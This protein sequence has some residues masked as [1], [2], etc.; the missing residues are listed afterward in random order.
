[1]IPELIIK[2]NMRKLQK[3]E[4][5]N[6]IY[7]AAGIILG[8]LAGL[9]LDLVFN[10]EYAVYI[11]LAILAILD[12]LFNMLYENLCGDLTLF[13][14]I[15]LLVGDLVFG[16]FLGYVGEQLGLPIYLAAVFA[17][18]NNIYVNLRSICDFMIEKYKKNK[19][20][21]TN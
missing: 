8:I 14:S 12:T 15:V 20:D 4:G 5:Y 17:F 1:M 9:N 18:G 16:L 7:I 13:R 2:L 21:K 3:D 19:T 6:M 10:P 11:S